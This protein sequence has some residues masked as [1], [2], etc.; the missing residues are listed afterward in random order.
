MRDIAYQ[1][2][3]SKA[4]LFQYFGTKKKMYIYLYQYAVNLIIKKLPDGTDDL[5][6]CIQK[7]TEAKMRILSEYPGMYDF[8]AS[9]INEDDPEILEDIENM[10]KK[11]TVLGMDMLFA[12]VDFG[13]FKPGIDISTVNNL[14]IWI[15]EGL[16]RSSVGSISAEDIMKELDIY[17]ELLKKTLYREEY[18]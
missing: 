15:S 18:L 4:S 10:N 14:L 13:R 2:G 12:K 3:I 16:I 6:E 9:S 5:F 11:N 7:I 1:A 17:M 8:I